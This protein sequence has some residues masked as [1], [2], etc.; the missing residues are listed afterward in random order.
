MSKTCTD[1]ASPLGRS[2]K[3]WDKNDYACGEAV[4]GGKAANADTICQENVRLCT[5]C[6]H[7]HPLFVVC[8][9]NDPNDITKGKIHGFC[10]ARFQAKSTLDFSRTY[11]RIDAAT[12]S[13]TIFVFVHGGS[14]SRAMFHAHATE[15]NRRHGHGSILLD[16]PGHGTLADFDTPLTLESCAT[17]L[18]KVLAECNITAQSKEKIIYVGGSLGAYVGFYLLARCNDIFDG[19][20]L[21]DCGQNVSTGSSCKAK[22]GLMVMAW[23]GKKLSNATLMGL[24]LD[25]SK[26]S[27]ADFKLVETVFGAG[28]RVILRET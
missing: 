12:N 5:T 8:E 20:V 13:R 16:L 14:S 2:W 28:K 7:R 18:E 26:K 23:M 15:L 19:A 6:F 10:K 22:A 4:S 11:D 17:T 24:M 21:M 9:G 25:I 27:T 1:C 3:F